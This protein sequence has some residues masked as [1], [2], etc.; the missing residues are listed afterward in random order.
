MNGAKNLQITKEQKITLAVLTLIN[1]FNYV[2]RQII[3]PLFDSIKL[4]FGVTDFQ[5]GLLGTLFM[6]VHAA[7]SVPFGV[8]AD[9]YSRKMVIAAGVTFWSV[10]TFLSGLAGNFKTLLA[11][12]SLVGIG[13]ASYAP[14]ATAIISD[15][16]PQKIRSQ[17]QGI[18]NVGMFAGGTIGVMLGGIIVYYFQSWRI[19]FFL[20]AIPGL[21]LA[22]A[23]A[24][25]KIHTNAE[26]SKE[27]HSIKQT[28]AKLWKNPAYVWL[29]ISGTLATFAAGTFIS[30]GIE[31][32]HRYKGYNLRD[33]ALVLGSTMLV[34][35][36]LGVILGSY[37]A[38]KAYSKFAWG[39]SMVI[40]LALLLAAPFALL[41]VEAGK[42][43]VFVVYFFIA[44]VLLSFYHGPVTAVIHDVVPKHIRA[45]AFAVYL[46]V[47]HLLGDALSPAIIGAISD[48]SGLKLGMELAVLM[49]FLSGLALLPVCH[50]IRTKKSPLYLTD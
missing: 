37:L 45:T 2:D 9:K 6:L 21:I 48:H 23:A 16:F 22:L 3:F 44:T 19:A 46:L 17:V 27:I 50:Y 39:R 32:I 10:V 34:A 25:L 8:L 26:P 29:L 33:A 43:I 42:G 36:V 38:D 30:W 49:I 7:T 28:A 18:F 14:A 12:R 4:E 15:V 1:F 31:F 5:L 40:A 20:V 41:G 47:I 35:G 13:E 11:L 24:K